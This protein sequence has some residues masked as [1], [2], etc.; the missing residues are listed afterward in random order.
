MRFLSSLVCLMLLVNTGVVSAGE[1]R[2]S[3]GNCTNVTDVLNEIEPGSTV[4]LEPG[5]YELHYSIKPASD[6]I[7]S[8]TNNSTVILYTDSFDD[9]SYSN[10]PAMIYIDDQKN[11][12]VNNI[13][14]VGPAKN[15]T[16]QHDNS[17]T[18]RI[19][20]LREARNGIKAYSSENVT[21]TNCTFTKLLSDGVR[22]SRTKDVTVEKC[23]FVSAGHDSI[24]IYKT[25]N[26]S[27][28]DNYFE[29][30]INTCIRFY[31][32]HNAIVE[33]CTFIQNWSGTGA[34]Y[35]EFQG[36]GSNLTISNNT[37]LQSSDPVCFNV[38]YAGDKYK[39]AGNNFS[40]CVPF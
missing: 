40:G 15:K 16:H 9:I 26:V 11:V 2:F 30:F 19:G 32:A 13:T 25:E 35:L 8:G 33:N 28:I 7:I 37:F 18:K 31:H 5:I 36:S 29:L 17:G 27:S 21:V 39:A 3:S 22:L 23:K 34:G 24:S 20:G 12:T 1:Y 14:F 6:F 4:Y 10:Q 38:G